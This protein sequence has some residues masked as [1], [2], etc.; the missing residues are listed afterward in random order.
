MKITKSKIALFAIILALIYPFSI[1]YKQYGWRWNP[2]EDSRLLW[3]EPDPNLIGKTFSIIKPAAYETNP[4]TIK[5]YMGQWH[6]PVDKFGVVG[7]IM[8]ED[9]YRGFCDI[10]VK[11]NNI[12]PEKVGYCQKLNLQPGQQT[13]QHDRDIKISP[14]YLIK[15]TDIFTI[16]KTYWI[17]KTHWM[18]DFSSSGKYAIVQNT[19]NQRF[20]YRFHDFKYNTTNHTDYAAYED[21]GNLMQQGWKYINLE[22]L[23]ESN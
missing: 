14:D 20:I 17:I 22:I 19:D 21:F 4:E 12:A 7:I 16:E 6:T 5:N 23:N 3:D 8:F 10:Y 11:R 18:H 13:S 1:Y 15:P 9:A 2:W